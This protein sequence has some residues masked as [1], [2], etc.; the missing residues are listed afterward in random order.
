[1]AKAKIFLAVGVW[2][3]ILPYLGFPSGLK[4][5]LF[6][7]TGFFIIY[8]SYAMYQTYRKENPRTNKSPDNFSENHD[9]NK[10]EKEAT[11]AETN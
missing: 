4:S 5:I 9:F 8:M 3:A 6:T 11:N 10:S 7:L 1:M 2:T